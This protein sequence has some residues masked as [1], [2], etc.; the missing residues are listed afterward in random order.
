MFAA[1]K[2]AEQ[3]VWAPIGVG[4]IHA[5]A[6]GYT[7]SSGAVQTYTWEA[8][9]SDIES[10]LATINAGGTAP[11]TVTT[12]YVDFQIYPDGS[13][14]NKGTLYTFS[15]TVTIRGTGTIAA[16]DSPPSSGT[17]TYAQILNRARGWYIDG[18]EEAQ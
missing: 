2:S 17:I 13:V 15:R 10:R 1:G 12:T 18:V 3:I 4:T 11:R 6:T 7:S 16:L 9:Y 5:W 8:L 14:D